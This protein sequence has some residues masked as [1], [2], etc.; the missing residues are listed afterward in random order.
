MTYN[1]FFGFS[2]SPFLDVPD[3]RFLFVSRQHEKISQEL[4]EF[5]SARRGVAVV[6]GEDGV[7]KTM[8]VQALLAR[9][10]QAFQPVEIIGL[11]AEPLAVTLLFAEALGITLRERNLVN[12]TALTDAVQAAAQQGKYYVMILDDA[13]A[14]TD[15]HLEEIYILSQIEQQGQQLLSIILAGRKGLVQKVASKA[16]QRL[17]ELIRTNIAIDGLTFEETPRYIDHRL[18]QVG[19][20]FQACFA[21]GCSGQLFSRTGGI[22]RRINQVCDQALTR[23]WQQNRPRVSRDLLGEEESAPSYKPLAPPS[24]WE[25]L[26]KYAA[27]LAGLLVVSL[28]SYAL[29]NFAFPPGSKP[30]PTAAE[31][32]PPPP[33]PLPAAPQAASPPAPPLLPQPHSQAAETRAGF[34]EEIPA[35][36]LQLFQEEEEPAQELTVAGLSE[37]LPPPEDQAPEPESSQP[38]TSYQVAPEDGLLRIVASRYPEDKELGYNAVILANPQ[39]TNENVIFPGQSL[40]LPRVDKNSRAITINNKQHFAFFKQYYAAPQVDKATAKL[41]DLLIKYQVRETILPDNIKTY[42]IFLGDY[43]NQVDLAQAAVLAEKIQ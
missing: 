3:Q 20:S 18:Q 37:E 33:V 2:E 9:L 13:H 1:S 23:A 24:R 8:V 32:T 15:Q 43:E 35:P 40:L 19:S 36:A 42:R 22:P 34:Q 17:R 39:I 21:E 38:T 6:S 7:G 31:T 29:Y 30:L 41:S 5:V 16:N 27:I 12:L 10:P 4:L 25:G 11:A 26:Q 28:A 14:L